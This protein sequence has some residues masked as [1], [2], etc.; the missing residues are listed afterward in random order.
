MK[1]QNAKSLSFVKKLNWSLV[2]TITTLLIIGLINLYSVSHRA[3]STTAHLFYL[4]LIWMALGFT[5]FFGVSFI[6]YHFFTRI[7]YFLYGIN[8]IF[9]ITVLLYGKELSGARRWL[10]L[11]LFHYQPSETLKIALIFLL[12]RILSVKRSWR[13]MSL[14]ELIKPVVFILLPVLCI[15]KQ[16][17][18]G[19]ALIILIITGSIIVFAKVRKNILLFFGL[20]VLCASPPAWHFLLKDYQKNRILTF[21][22]PDRD[23]RG[24]GYNSIQSKI[25]IG[26][27]QFLGKG[28]QK[29]TQSQLKFLPERHTD[30]I[31]SVLSEEHGFIGSLVTVALFFFLIVIGFHTAFQSKDKVGVFLCVGMSFY[32]FW[33]IFINIGMTMG[34]LPVV[35]IP[36]PLLSYGGS[37]LLSVMTALGVISS[38]S[39]RRGLF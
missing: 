17:D 8:L 31:F 34:L 27:G 33:H 37:S 36:L 6:N 15:L 2:V 14:I 32:I 38:V 5:V 19:T 10:D 29:G 16:P 35:G 13:S 39:C 12:A 4:Q 11:G 26:S 7:A 3:H 28:F 1:I 18:L 20:F 9:L 22:S 21:I 23:P 30:F 24:A 25:A